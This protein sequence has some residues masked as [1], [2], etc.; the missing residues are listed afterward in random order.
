M[1]KI[2]THTVYDANDPMT[3]SAPLASAL[4]PAPFVVEEAGSDTTTGSWGYVANSW[5]FDLTMSGN[6]DQVTTGTWGGI[7]YSWGLHTLPTESMDR[8]SLTSDANPSVNQ[9]IG[10]G[11]WDFFPLPPPVPEEKMSERDTTRYRKAYSS[12]RYQPRRIRYIKRQ[13]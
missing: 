4:A 5:G 12:Q 13:G 3:G 10:G 1:P 7:D 8:F 6:I 2:Y 11:E 9:G